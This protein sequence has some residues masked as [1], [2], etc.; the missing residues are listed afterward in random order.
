MAYELKSIAILN[1]EG[2]DYKYILW[3][4]SK[5]DAVDRLNNSVL[6]NKDVFKNDFGVMLI[7]NSSRFYRIG[8][9]N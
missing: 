2:V 3:G 6:E 7:V 8:V 1:A 4:I 9:M 5:N